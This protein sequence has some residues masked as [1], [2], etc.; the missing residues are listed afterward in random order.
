M[1]CSTA[2]VGAYS[3]HTMPSH[4]I[5]RTGG[6]GEY[7]LVELRAICTVRVDHKC[8]TIADLNLMM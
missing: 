8:L 2:H 4:F 3:V 6:Y 1:I 5:V 7:L